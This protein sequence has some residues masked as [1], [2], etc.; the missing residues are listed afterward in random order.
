MRASTCSAALRAGTGPSCD[1][2]AYERESKESERK[3][4]HRDK[5]ERE[6]DRAPSE[7]EPRRSQTGA[8]YLRVG[9]QSFQR[10]SLNV[11]FSL[12]SLTHVRIEVR[13]IEKLRQTPPTQRH[14]RNINQDLGT[15]NE[16]LIRVE[17]CGYRRR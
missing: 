4:K 15:V 5:R 14:E 7:K 12:Q 13:T 11:L 2:R 8:G 10:I 1:E 16:T 17:V 6:K 9:A 3:E